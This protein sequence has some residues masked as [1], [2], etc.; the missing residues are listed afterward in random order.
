MR[1]LTIGGNIREIKLTA[2]DLGAA[3]QQILKQGGRPIMAVF[4]GVHAGLFAKYELEWIVWAAWRHTWSSERIQAELAT[5]YRE[6]GT[7]I[8]LHTEV[9]EAVI[10]TGL[11]GRRT[12]SNGT[13]PAAD[14]PT[15][16]TSG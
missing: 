7:L 5:F 15:A 14:P 12:A 9:L 6:G 4:G 8:D 3:E 2:Q 10:D 13:E 1:S 11:Y 16:G